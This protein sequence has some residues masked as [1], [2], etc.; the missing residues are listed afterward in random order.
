MVPYWAYE[1]RCKTRGIPEAHG[2]LDPHLRP[3]VSTVFR[4][5]TQEGVLCNACYP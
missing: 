4:A 1:L 5:L 3:F 2:L